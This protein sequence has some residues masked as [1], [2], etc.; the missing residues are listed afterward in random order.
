MGKEM[1]H[2]LKSAEKKKKN[3]GKKQSEWGSGTLNSAL[4]GGKKTVLI[5]SV[6]KNL[7]CLRQ[8][9]GGLQIGSTGFDLKLS[10]RR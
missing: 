9:G 8:S 5:M 6:L 3:Y 1:R 2:T 10:V 4:R 7:T